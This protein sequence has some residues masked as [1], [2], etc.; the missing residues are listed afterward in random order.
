MYKL[1]DKTTN[2]TEIGI[3]K[4]EEIANRGEE[5]NPDELYKDNLFAKA[6]VQNWLR[7]IKLD[8]IDREKD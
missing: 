3:R 1:V 6:E 8:M 5:I 7:L 2:K 4:A